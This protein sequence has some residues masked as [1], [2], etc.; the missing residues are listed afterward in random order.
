MGILRFKTDL[1]QA[2]ANNINKYETSYNSLVF[3]DEGWVYFK[4]FYFFKEFEIK[5]KNNKMFFQ[6]ELDKEKIKAIPKEDMKK[7][8][9][10]DIKT[11]LQECLIQQMVYETMNTKA[12]Y[13]MMSSF[14][15]KNEFEENYDTREVNEIEEKKMKEI[16]KILKN[17]LG[18]ETRLK[19]GEAYFYLES[20]LKGFKFDNQKLNYLF[21]IANEIDIFSIVPTFKN[22]NEID[23][24]RLFFG[25]DL[26]I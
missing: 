11:R 21:N 17:K 2:L 6:I 22:D 8:K 13:E 10:I 19:K 4:T 7:I 1:Q 18:L 15:E 24:I 26:T 23:G 9:E 12:Q 20:N 5:V 3:E 16:K 14:L 25:I